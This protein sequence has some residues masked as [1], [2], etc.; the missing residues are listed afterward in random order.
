[1]SISVRVL[2]L[3][4]VLKVTFGN[5]MDHIEFGSHSG[6]F[7]LHRQILVILSLLSS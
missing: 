3:K 7:C 5:K 4:V 2:A 6:N 1:M